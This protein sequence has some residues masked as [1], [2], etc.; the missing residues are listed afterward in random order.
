MTQKRLLPALLITLLLALQTF[1]QQRTITGKVTDNTGA[2]VSGATVTVKGTNIATSTGSD[3]SY[4]INV[5]QEA[6]TLVISAV[7][8]GNLEAA[9]SGSSVDVSITPTQSNLNEVV[10]VGYGTARKRDLTGAVASV[11]AKDFNQGVFAS[12]DNLIQGKVAGVQVINNTGAPGGASTIRIRG[13]SSIRAG[14]APLIVVDGVPLSGGS[15]QPGLDNALGSTPGDNPLNF[16]N[17]ADI[18]SMDILKDASATAIYGSRGANGVIVITTK[19]GSS[20]APK[21][22]FTTQVGVANM[23]RQ[24]KVLDAAGYRDA[25]KEYNLSAGDYGGNVN[26]MDEITR[27]AFT[28]NYN[29][30]V[31]GGNDNGK[32]RLSVGY[33]NQEGIIQE[34]GFKKITANLASSFKFTESK[35]LGLDFNIIFGNTLTNQAPIGNT[36]GFQGS[37][38]GQALQW[39][40]TH[41]LRKPNDSIW[42]NNQLGATTINPLAM[43]A[44]YDDKTSL[45]N[46]IANISPSYKILN[47]LEYR[48][49]YAVNYSTAER[50]SSIRN[51]LNF[52]GNLGSA[53][54]GNNR[55]VNQTITHTLSYTPQLT[56]N[57]NMNA[58]VGYEYLR[59]DFKGSGMQANRFFDYPQLD[60]TDYMQNS[61]AADRN[62]FSYAPPVNE[63]QSLF[64]RA[65][66]S[67]GD[68]FILMGTVRRDGSSK[69]G[70][71]N[72]YG[73]FPAVSGAWNISNESFVSSS[74]AISNLKLRASWGV[75]G[76]QEFPSG[77]AQRR[78]NI[79]IGDNTSVANFENPDVKWETNTM[80]NVGLD[81]GFASNR[82]TGT[83][84]WFNRKT[85]DPLF[86]ATPVAPA[87]AAGVIW[88]NLPASIVN[89][90]LELALNFNIVR[91]ENLSWNLGGNIA[92][93]QNEVKDLNG[94]Y[95]T[96]ALNGQGISGATSQ[97][98]VEDQPLNVYY[99]RKF[100]GFDKTTGQSIYAENEKL[101]YS[102]SPNPTRIYGITTD[103]TWKKLFASANMNGAAGHYLYNNTA[104]SVINVGNLGTRN[105]SAAIPGTGENLSNAI[106]P[107]TR[108]LEKG[109]YL[110]LANATIGYRIG[111]LGRAF[112]NVTVTLTGQNLFVISKFTGFDPEVNVDKNVNGI[113]SAGIE[114]IPYPS[115]RTILLGLTFGL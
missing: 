55:S 40:P 72:R 38:I 13:I 94:S 17:S 76:N 41:P 79:G 57:I 64:A 85:S 2:P 77:V 61:P 112:K 12:P 100:E 97:L 67:F 29:L 35:R 25:L 115:A 11:K 56:K 86:A 103:L 6:G 39:N 87:P 75:T 37:L 104:N 91:T 30:A 16:I 69:F 71:N 23:L 10:V 47:N 50:R 9:I 19:K 82:I 28:Q 88:Q 42:I 92:F 32:Y 83:V 58:V 105:I 70:A 114:Y 63:I 8:Y 7:G 111:S 43:I 46:I 110:K 15:T 34:S 68:R 108:Y 36:S 62:V 107:S 24:I 113:P 51:W 102:G 65:Q 73:I 59:Y 80:V 66:F 78:V 27:S 89:T 49:L 21:I 74:K 53:Q 52:T 96:G 5:P 95:Q 48:M 99:L 101:F 31:S 33:M 98:I 20:G 93:L 81:F 60:Y 54:I 4:K 44:A 106:A 84:D 90:G 26:A 1:A 45:N 14:N 3:G 18:A 109:D 22:D